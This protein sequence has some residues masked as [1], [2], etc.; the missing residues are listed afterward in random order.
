[1]YLVL[2]PRPFRRFA[3][4]TTSRLTL[5]ASRHQGLRQVPDN[6]ENPVILDSDMCPYMLIPHGPNPSKPLKRCPGMRTLGDDGGE[7]DWE[8]KRLTFAHIRQCWRAATAWI[9][10]AS[11]FKEGEEA[12]VA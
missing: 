8:M 6:G 2:P 1:M 11:V 7:V 4:L 3:L 12:G 9:N 10:E 5:T